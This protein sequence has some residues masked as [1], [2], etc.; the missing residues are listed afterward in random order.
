[1][2][3][4]QFSFNAKFYRLSHK[5]KNRRHNEQLFEISGWHL[6]VYF[7]QMPE[8]RDENNRLITWRI[9]FFF[10]SLHSVI[11]PHQSK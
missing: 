6:F 8:N 1:M 10:I 4:L 9:H 5:S 2:Y 3:F 11:S 7:L